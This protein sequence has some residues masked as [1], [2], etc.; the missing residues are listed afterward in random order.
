[1]DGWVFLR[2]S[3]A[4][5][6]YSAYAFVAADVREFDCRDGF[7]V[8]PGCCASGGVK[9]LRS[10]V[11]LRGTGLLCDGLPLWQTPV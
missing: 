1:M 10:V 2:D 4:Q 11:S 8:G 6:D 7:A 3:G 5:S 9:V